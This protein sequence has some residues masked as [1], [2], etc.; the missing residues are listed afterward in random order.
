MEKKKRKHVV[1]IAVFLLALISLL[2]LVL[3][4]TARFQ[5]TV[6]IAERGIVV[7]EEVNQNL[8]MAREFYAVHQVEVDALVDKLQ[9]IA[10]DSLAS[11]VKE[12]IKGGIVDGLKRGA[13]HFKVQSRLYTEKKD[14]LRNDLRSSG[15]D[16]QDAYSA[17]REEEDTDIPGLF[18]RLVDELL[19][20]Q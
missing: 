2:L 5:E 3:H 16:W 13:N 17:A 1:W 10:P 6:K 19:N 7:A 11:S 8:A 15:I 14:K 12:G 18:W 20:E 9:A 4:I